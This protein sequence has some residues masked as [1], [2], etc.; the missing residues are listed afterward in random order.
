MR[1]RLTTT[2][3]LVHATID[4]FQLLDLVFPTSLSQ[5]L[6]ETQQKRSEQQTQLALIER[7]KIDAVGT[8]QKA[9]EEAQGIIFTAEAKK[10]AIES[11]STVC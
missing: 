9:Q 11:V 4:D 3:S 5:A 8:I 6:E 7:E 1:S 10:V 2:I